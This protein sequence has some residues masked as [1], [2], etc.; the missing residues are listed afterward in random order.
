M[1]SKQYP[2]EVYVLRKRVN[3]LSEGRQAFPGERVNLFRT[4]RQVLKKEP[5]RSQPY[6]FF[7]NLVE[8]NDSLSAISIAI[9]SI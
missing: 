5:K 7:C 2:Y 1:R 8:K 9:Y 6:W 4:G 3:H